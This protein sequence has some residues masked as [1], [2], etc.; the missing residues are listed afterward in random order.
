MSENSKK[1]KT[2]TT[3]IAV[4]LAIVTVIG[5][6]TYA[7]LQGNTDHV[8]NA[9]AANQVSV[10]LKES[11]GGKYNIIP[12]TSEAKDPTVTVNTT[13]PAYV[14]VEV[15]DN[16]ENLVTYSI[17][18]GWQMLEGFENVYYREADGSA[19]EQSFSVL[20]NNSVSYAASIV[21]NDMLVQNDDGTY[22]LKIGRAHV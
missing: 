13:V 12:G 16:T 7:Y 20:E 6:T 10:E 15:T 3:A 18:N 22:S 14:Y 4:I 2:L 11:T 19:S 1:R 8:V 17:E 9:F 21:N 5:S